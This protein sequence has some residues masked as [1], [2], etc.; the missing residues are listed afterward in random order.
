MAAGMQID[1][2]LDPERKWLSQSVISSPEALNVHSGT[3][4][5]DRSGQATVQLPRYFSA[6]NGNENLRYQL[7]AIGAAA[8]NLHVARKV[9]GNRFQIAG[10][11]PVQE[12][13]WQVSGVRRD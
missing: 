7:T 3:V 4:T 11:N 5:L 8:P 1:H 12:F 9:Q 10:G 6:L 13:S 2:P